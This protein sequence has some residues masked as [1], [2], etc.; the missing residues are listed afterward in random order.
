MIAAARRAAVAVAAVALALPAGAAAA[1]G[2][3]HT[4]AGSTPGFGGDGGPATAAQLAG[5]QD[6]LELRDGSV[7]IA[8]TG[9][10]RVRRVAPDG[11]ITT[12][13]GTGAA[14]SGGDGGPATDAQLRPIAL[15]QAADGAILV[16][17]SLGHR[18]RRIAQGVITTVAGTGTPGFSGDGGPADAAQLD[19]P[20]GVAA[21]ADGGFVISDGAKPPRPARVPDRDH[22]DDRGHRHVRVQ[23]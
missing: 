9:N 11:T 7:L 16:V 19:V 8:D 18:I 10:H 1:T 20:L 13:A 4:V 12:F 3:I 2:V 6:V 21:T 15:A 14:A 5:P 17:D 22:H 23:R